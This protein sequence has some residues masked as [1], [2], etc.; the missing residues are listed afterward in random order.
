MGVSMIDGTIEAMDLRRAAA[1][2]R[3][4]NRIVFRLAD[5]GTKTIAKPYVHTDLAEQLA[6]GTS[7]R[8][9]LFASIDHR[10]VQAMR[11]DD[12][13]AIFAYPKNNEVVGMVLLVIGL[14]WVGAAI[15]LFD[16]IP[17]LGAIVLVI[18]ILVTVVNR[19]LRL[20][21]R[22]QFDADRGHAPPPAPAR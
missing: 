1:K 7:G 2:V 10:G 9:Y 3:I 11:A 21:A 12:G 18:A 22:R 13:R 14:L 17:V 16:G 5:G 19:K 20:D 8:F 15:A 6:P 4:Y